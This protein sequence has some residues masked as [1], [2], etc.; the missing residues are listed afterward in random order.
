[1]DEEMDHGVSYMYDSYTSTV[2]QYGTYMYANCTSDLTSS[3]LL[4]EWNAGTS[5]KRYVSQKG[6]GVS[7]RVRPGLREGTGTCIKGP[8]SK[9]SAGG[10]GRESRKVNPVCP[11]PPKQ[12]ARGAAAHTWF[13]APKQS[14]RA[15][16]FVKTV[17]VQHRH[18]V[19]WEA[20]N[21][22]GHAYAPRLWT[23]RASIL[24]Q[25]YSD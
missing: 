4:S 5:Q 9:L 21:G 17:R 24:L 22:S 18:V 19:A 6:Y 10:R 7:E 2:G 13:T 3:I 12:R 25:P 15:E 16:R 11:H 1:M 8:G 20:A 23:L 14:S